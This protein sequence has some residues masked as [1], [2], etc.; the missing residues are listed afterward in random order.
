MKKFVWL[1]ALFLCLTGCAKQQTFETVSDEILSPVSA[2]VQQTF[3]QLPEGASATVMET[4]GGRLYFWDDFTV[5][6]FVTESGDLDQTVQSV[7]GFS[8]DQLQIMQTQWGD[9]KRYD[10]VW[11]A[12]GEAGQQLCRASILDDGHYHYILMASSQAEQAGQLQQTWIQMFD[13][14]RLVSSDFPLDT[15]S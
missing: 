12:A 3:V 11:T 2:T 13:S 4:D 9:T 15:G 5:S 6:C 8:A 14:F 1:L 7:S 10:F